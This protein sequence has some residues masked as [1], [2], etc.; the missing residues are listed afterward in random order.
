MQPKAGRGFNTSAF[1]TV[2]TTGWASAPARNAQSHQVTSDGKIL[3]VS[4]IPHI[5][6]TFPPFLLHFLSLS[7]LLITG[8][9]SG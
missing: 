9:K 3:R 5:V 2:L 7:F 1:L 8:E 4:E 6:F